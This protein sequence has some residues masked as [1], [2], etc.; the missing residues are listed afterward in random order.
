MSIFVFMN[1]NIPL[2]IF[3]SKFHKIFTRIQDKKQTNTK[4]GNYDRL[5]PRFTC[6]VI[7]I[8]SIPV[9][10]T[11]GTGMGTMTWVWVQGT[12]TSPACQ[13]SRVR[14]RDQVRGYRY[15]LPY[16]DSITTTGMGNFKFAKL[17]PLQL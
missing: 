7:M 1:K 14:V 8:L 13:E 12:G 4:L 2:S 16:P 17:S 5:L 15:K 11:M 10:E 3:L 9:S 6:R